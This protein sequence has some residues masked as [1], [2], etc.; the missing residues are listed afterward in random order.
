[1]KRLL[2]L[3]FFVVFGQ[4]LFGQDCAADLS[5]QKSDLEKVIVEIDAKFEDKDKLKDLPILFKPCVTNAELKNIRKIYLSLKFD[6]P[7]QQM[8]KTIIKKVLEDNKL[9]C[10]NF[11]NNTQKGINK[12]YVADLDALLKEYEGLK[13][14]NIKTNTYN[15]TPTENNYNVLNQLKSLLND[16]V[17]SEN[18]KTIKNLNNQI[19]TEG[20]NGGKTMEFNA[21]LRDVLILN[22]ELFNVT[23]VEDTSKTTELE[24]E[25]QESSSNF[26]LH[27]FLFYIPLIVLTFGGY[28]LYEKSLNKD[29]SQKSK[30]TIN[31]TPISIENVREQKLEKDNKELREILKSSDNNINTEEQLK[32]LKVK[33]NLIASQQ[34]ELERLKAEIKQ[35]KQVKEPETPKI[36]KLLFFAEADWQ[37]NFIASNATKTPKLGASIYKFLLNEESDEAVFVFYNMPSTFLSAMN[38]PGV[39][40]FNVCIADNDFNGNANKIET[41]KMGKAILKKGKWLVAEKALIRFSI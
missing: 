23:T 4:V 27:L 20:F 31:T 25:R 9:L 37:G 39:K 5:K 22:S 32:A 16:C 29:T 2:F 14:K 17:V 8:Y 3:L 10:V 19:I 13:A 34:R 41:V 12:N 40:L 28:F 7:Q 18:L 6:A 24:S 35:L 15:G 33:D 38:N 1:M 36:E 21:N 30:N 26:W 11:A